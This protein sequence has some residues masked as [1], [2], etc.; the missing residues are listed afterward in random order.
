LALTGQRERKLG[1][2]ARA[3]QDQAGLL[4]LV[5]LQEASRLLQFIF[6]QL[7]LERGLRDLG[8]PQLLRA[9]QGAFG[10]GELLGGYGYAR[11]A[12]T[13]EPS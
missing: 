13:G 1:V 9:A 2:G 3:Q 6:R 12:E 11:T 4:V 7:Q 5:V 10:L 8:R